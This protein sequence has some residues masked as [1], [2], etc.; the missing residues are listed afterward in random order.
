MKYQEVS[1][2]VCAYV[3][4]FRKRS[5]C[6]FIG[7]GMFIITNT[8][9]RMQGKIITDRMQSVKEAIYLLQLGF[10]NNIPQQCRKI[11]CIDHC[12][13]AI[14]LVR[15]K[16]N[17]YILCIWLCVLKWYLIYIDHEQS[18]LTGSCLW[19]IPKF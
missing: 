18:D 10:K 16:L 11:N 13:M 6:V 5:V 17:F 8:I 14:N 19:H 1:L 2:A 15:M 7:A 9:S 4:I 12:L 3:Q